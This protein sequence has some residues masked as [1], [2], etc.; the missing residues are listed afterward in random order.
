[1]GRLRG[2][3]VLVGGYHRAAG[4]WASGWVSGYFS[5]SRLLLLI[6]KCCAPCHTAPLYSFTAALSTL[7][8][9][10]PTLLCHLTNS[11]LLSIYNELRGVWSGQG[12]THT[13]HRTHA[14]SH[15][16]CRARLDVLT[17]TDRSAAPAGRGREC[18]GSEN[19]RRERQ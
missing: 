10:H 9:H 15:R 17:G 11:S 14:P 13:A 1:M 8:C 12:N 5:F 7:S 16:A 3:E 2:R 4:G 19:D 6:K 18:V